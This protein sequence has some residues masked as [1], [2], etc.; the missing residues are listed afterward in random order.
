MSE[1][2]NARVG[3]DRHKTIELADTVRALYQQNPR[4]TVTKA[5][6]QTLLGGLGLAD[7]WAKH[8]ADAGR[9]EISLHADEASGASGF[10]VIVGESIGEGGMARVE[11]AT[12]GS[13]N[14]EVALKRV[15]P[16][17][18]STEFGVALG[19][20]AELMARLDHANI[21]PVYQRAFTADGHPLILMKRVRGTAWSTLLHSPEHHLW[22]ENSGTRL[23]ANLE[24]FR[25]VCHAV[26][27]AHDKRIIHRDLK[28]ENVMVGDFGEVYLLDW[29]VAVELDELGEHRDDGFLGTPCF[30]APEMFLRVDP[31]TR[32][33]DV[34]LLGAM[35]HELLTGR[36]LHRGANLDEVIKSSVLSKPRDY[37]A[38]V[39]PAL[40][41]VA[42][43]ATARDP[44]NRYPSVR[45]LREA[46]EE[47]LN[48]YQALE[49]LNET[50]RDLI[51]LEELYATRHK[52]G[53]RFHQV[54]FKCGFGF[55]RVATIAPDLPG[56]SEGLLRVLELQISHE[57]D[58][59]R[60][61]AP[62]RLLS[63]V[64]KMHMDPKRLSVLETRIHEIGSA[65]QKAGELATQ[66]QYK[67]LEELQA[68]D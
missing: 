6:A 15:R 17:R 28:T 55:E 45:K 11:A 34:Y 58:Q 37:P 60:I 7:S 8:E 25:Q 68:K 4:S 26:E 49:L 57:L 53:F 44:Q 31:L 30:A 52:D 29:G 16:D 39:H 14:R 20:E 10:T 56:V 33:T 59:G 40:A 1:D 41:L 62:L 48:H 66:I 18:Y 22:S 61:E 32:M 67:L 46:I 35:L 38:T 47:H 9:E 23:E 63:V 21:P 13:L 50:R 3:R 12:Q 2:E 51:V 24:V 54:A 65:Q 19:Q 27:Y 64:R 36:L 42:N 43:Q 5:H